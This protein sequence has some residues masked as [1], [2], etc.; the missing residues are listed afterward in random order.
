MLPVLPSSACPRRSLFR[1]A[2]A[3]VDGGPDANRSVR[4]QTVTGDAAEILARGAVPD[5]QKLGALAAKHGYEIL[6]PETN[7]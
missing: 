1:S 4:C 6:Q 2:E 5:V 7:R 3:E